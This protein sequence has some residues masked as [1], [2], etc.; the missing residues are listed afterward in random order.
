MN[1]IDIAALGGHLHEAYGTRMPVAPLTDAHPDLQLEDAYRIQLHQVERWKNSGRRVSGYKVGLTSLA[2]QRQLGVDQPDF[3]HLFSDMIV[4]GSAVDAAAFISPKIEPEIAFVLK[5]DL[6]GPGL[7]LVDVIGAVDYAI[8]SLEIIDSRVADWKIKLADTIADNASS[9]AVVLGN[10]PVRLDVADLG[11][12]GCILTRNGDVVATGA[13]AAVLGN[14]L[15]GVL[16]LANK[17]GSLGQTLEEGSVVM[18][19]SITAAVPIAPGDVFT[20]TFAHLGDVR[21]RFTAA[22]EED[23]V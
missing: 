21:A 13:G 14:P 9:G 11:L 15:N 16:W 7:S 19:G 1:D 18:A 3:G 8:A 6:R 10:R 22:S 5:H 17:L 4:D 12:A 23:A 2:M 20:A